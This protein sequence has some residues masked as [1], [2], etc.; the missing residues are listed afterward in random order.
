MKKARYTYID[1]RD[2]TS[3]LENA[4]FVGNI[5]FVYCYMIVTHQFLLSVTRDTAV[6]PTSYSEIHRGSQNVH[7][8][9]CRVLPLADLT[10]RT[11]LC[12]MYSEAVTPPVEPIIVRCANIDWT[13]QVGP[14]YIGRAGDANP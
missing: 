10:T 11:E 7:V 14:K 9:S 3:A 5:I 1:L 6:S 2:R 12:R 8:T 4:I 13:D